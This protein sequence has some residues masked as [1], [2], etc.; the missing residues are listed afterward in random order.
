M[1]YVPGLPASALAVFKTGDE[2]G[3]TCADTLGSED[4][5]TYLPRVSSARSRFTAIADGL[6]ARARTA[7]YRSCLTLGADFRC[8]GDLSS[9]G[10]GVRLLGPAGKVAAGGQGTG[11]LGAGDPL[12]D[13]QQRGELVAGRDRIPRL[14][15]PAGEVGAGGQ[16]VAVLG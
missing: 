5:A 15:G 1:R 11:V 2:A 10:L 14:P 12:D 13:R 6:A 3:L 7:G 4:M 16:G 8:R 9:F